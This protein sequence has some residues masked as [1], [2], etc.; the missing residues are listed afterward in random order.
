[1]III[2]QQNRTRKVQLMVR[3]TEEERAKIYE[4]MQE[5]DTD[6]FSKY[7][8]DILLNGKVYTVDLTTYHELANEVKKIGINVNQI[9]RI[10]NQ[11]QNINQAEIDELKE[12]INKVWQ[13]L[14][15]SLLDV[16]SK[17]Q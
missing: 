17:N 11:N 2:E 9:A 13:L 8:R 5:Y 16:Q 14:K 4:K 15:L 10:S 7:A 6:N 1:M 3:V 12:I